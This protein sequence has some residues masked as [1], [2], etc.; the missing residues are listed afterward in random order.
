MS[1]PILYAFGGWHPRADVVIGIEFAVE[2]LAAAAAAVAAVLMTASLVYSWRYFE[3]TTQHYSALMLVFLVGMTGFALSGDLF[4]MFVFFELMGVCAF[5]LTGYDVKRPGPIQG[6]IN[7]AVTNSI[8][9]F[10]ILIGVALLYGRTGALNLAQIGATLAGKPVDGLVVVAFALLV[11]GFLVKAGAVPFH[12]WLSDA[13]AVAPVTVGVLLSGAMSDLGI[14][15]VER[16][17]WAVFSDGL[18]NGQAAVRAVLTAVAAATAVVGA[19]MAFLQSNLKRMLAFVT[20]SQIGIALAGVALLTAPGLAGASLAVVAQGLTRG[21]LFLVVGLVLHELR[22]DDELRLRGRGRQMLPAGALL[23][24]AALG[25]AGLPPFGPFLGTALVEQAA[26]AAGYGWLPA[27]LALAA[28]VSAGA[29]VR[30]AGRVFLGAGGKSDVLL[31]RQPEGAEA[32]EAD[33]AAARSRGGAAGGG[34]GTFA[35]SA[36]RRPRRGGRAPRPRP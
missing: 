12:F 34:A 25:L 19:A 35:R 7:F 36:D 15:A 28:I 20:V 23:V 33:A 8:G 11:S 3:D 24:A 32:E 5:A 16:V 14:H 4:N 26:A 9:G 29:L 10:L 18:G 27:V 2:P 1:R 30:A 22:D 6:A 13:Y 17:Y 31:A 21:G